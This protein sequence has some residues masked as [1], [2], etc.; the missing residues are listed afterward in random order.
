MKETPTLP[1]PPESDRGGFRHLRGLM[2]AKRYNLVELLAT[3]GMAA[4][5]NQ[6]ITYVVL[7]VAMA[8]YFVHTTHNQAV[9]DADNDVMH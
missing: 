2:L 8:G 4:V 1:P 6:I 9:R 3:G 5:Y 7:F